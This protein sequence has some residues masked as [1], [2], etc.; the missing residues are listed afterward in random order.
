MPT[1]GERT[2]AEIV[3]R[4]A[5][6]LNAR[7]FLAT[8][9]SAIV[10]ATGLQK[11]GLY[12]HFASREALGLAALDF[13]VAQVRDR[14]LQALADGPADACGQL[15]AL[16]DA[17]DPATAAAADGAL[18]LPGGCPIM[19]AAIE[20]DHADPALRARAQAAMKGWQSLVQSLVA[21]GISRGEIRADAEPQQ[22]ATVFIACIEGAVMLSHL[23]R[24]AAPL[25]AVR[26]HLRAHVEHTL[27]PPK[28]SPP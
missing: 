1:K 10:A 21:R 17:Y 6:L 19:N 22:V 11:G 14:F 13:A 12:R 16:L 24:S 18:P 15:L 3:R 28:G 4:S 8:P 2:R 7:G 25:A 9:V 5:A 20:A 26:A 23:Q 27:R